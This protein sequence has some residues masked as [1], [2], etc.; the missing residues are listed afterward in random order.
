MVL[1]GEISMRVFAVGAYSNHF[2][3]EIL[4]RFVRVSEAASLG[5]TALGEVFGVEIDDHVLLSKKILQRNITSIAGGKAE[6]RCDVT[7]SEQL[8]RLLQLCHGLE[9]K[10]FSLKMH[11]RKELSILRSVT[12]LREIGPFRGSTSGLDKGPY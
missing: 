4:E 9:K 11:L 2:C 3:A 6:T 12:R 7:N 10:R 5:C 8:L 1:L